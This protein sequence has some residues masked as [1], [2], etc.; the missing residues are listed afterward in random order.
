MIN[1]NV[2]VGARIKSLRKS[3]GLTQANLGEQVDLPQPYIGGIEKGER[4]ISLDTLQ[5]LLEALNIT[6]AELFNSYEN[7]LQNKETLEILDRINESLSNRSTEEIKIVESFV[8]DILKTIDN[9]RNL[10]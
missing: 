3:K 9:L 1:I 2:Y 7:K 6:P 4:N 8:Q 5:K 10:R